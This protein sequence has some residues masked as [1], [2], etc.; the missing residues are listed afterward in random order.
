MWWHSSVGLA[1]GQ[2][3][4]CI[5]DARWSSC[6]DGGINRWLLR[7]REIGR[8]PS[9]ANTCSQQR[10]VVNWTAKFIIILYRRYYYV[11]Y[12]FPSCLASFMW[13]SPVSQT[14]R[15]ACLPSGGLRDQAPLLPYPGGRL[16]LCHK[17]ESLVASLSVCL[18][19]NE[20]MQISEAYSV[21]S[22]PAVQT[23]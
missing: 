15:V 14:L 17:Y 2:Y 13:D 20:W 18:V 8:C 12:G 11:A 16:A 7:M 5:W 10:Y 19:N 9:S 3:W 1:N 4:R 6:W 22:V 23:W 21:S